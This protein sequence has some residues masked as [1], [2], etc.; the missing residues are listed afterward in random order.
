M[1]TFSKLTLKISGIDPLAFDLDGGRQVLVNDRLTIIREILF[2]QRDAPEKLPGSKA[3]LTLESFLEPGPLVQSDHPDIRAL[4]RRIMDNQK[5]SQED[6]QEDTLR[7]N[8][9]D[10]HRDIRDSA[11][12]KIRAVL[13][14]IDDNI[15]KRPLVS[16]PNA[17]STLE[18]R[19]GDCNEHAVLF[20]ALCRSLGIPTRI[21]AG[22]VFIDDRFYYHAWNGV[23]L[24][25]W[26]TVDFLFNEFPADVTH[27]RLI[28][29]QGAEGFDIMGAIGKIKIEITGTQ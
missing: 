19:M 20:A 10:S 1:K 24:G 29:G 8:K 2:E 26:I 9:G 14:W 16:L 15:E 6:N 4:A 3:V 28:S 5:Y 23:F 7:D 27:L 17:I 18:N 22:L 11:N 25:S 13:T 12:R 21:E